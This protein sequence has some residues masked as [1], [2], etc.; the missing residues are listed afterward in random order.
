MP[1][2]P[3]MRRCFVPRNMWL[4][5]SPG[6]A[7]PFSQHPM[8]P[9]SHLKPFICSL[10]PSPMGR[11]ERSGSSGVIPSLRDLEQQISSPKVKIWMHHLNI[12]IYRSIE[13][14]VISDC[15]GGSS[16]PSLTWP[17]R[18]KKHKLNQLMPFLPGQTTGV[19]LVSRMQVPKW[20]CQQFGLLHAM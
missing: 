16:T 18:R 13:G 20:S 19:V 6:L 12:H 7:A 17:F 4:W 15:T 5:G 11:Q 8:S 14:K 10:G 1:S 2:S 9:G 3:A